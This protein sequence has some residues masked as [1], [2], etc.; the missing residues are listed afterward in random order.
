[1][2]ELAKVAR[3]DPDAV[4]VLQVLSHLQ[5]ETG[6]VER[7][8]QVHQALLARPDLTRAERAHALASLGAD[9]R[10]AG[11]LDRAAQAFEEALAVDPNN[12]HALMGLRKVHEDQRHWREA[13]EVQT[14]L[15][16]L[17]KTNDGLVLGHLQA[18]IGVRT[19]SRPGPEAAETAFKAALALDRRVFPA[20]LGLADLSR[21]TSP[22]GRRPMLEERSRPPRSA[23]TWPSTGSSAATPPRRA[24]ALR[25]CA[26]GSS[27]RMRAT[28]G[29]GS[30]WPA[31][32][33]AQGGTRG[34]RPL[35]RAVESNPQALLVHL[36]LWRRCGPLGALGRGAVAVLWPR[37]RGRLLRRP[38][39]LHGLPLPRR[40]H[41]L[42]LPALPRVG[43][44]RGGAGRAHGRGRTLATE[45]RRGGAARMRG[46]APCSAGSATRRHPRARPRVRARSQRPGPHPGGQRVGGSRRPRARDPAATRGGPRPSAR[47]APPISVAGTRPGARGPRPPPRAER[48]RRRRR[49]RARGGR[50][51]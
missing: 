25:R 42:A 50:D 18:E 23:P 5:R 47:I 29:P 26:S 2:S 31:I 44:L 41:A 45:P 32:C 39:P 43:H 10:K 37:R 30:P 14:R 8:I 9:F 48:E 17:R 16:R 1:M 4:D 27:A 7:A 15:A 46:N 33:A 40:R 24:R 36:E 21:A 51:R 38:A 34:A 28:G 12:I 11:F 22:R 19:R 35:L 6:Q 13:Y 49:R 20:H 3:E